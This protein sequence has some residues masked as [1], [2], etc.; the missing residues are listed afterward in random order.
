MEQ[1]EPAVWLWLLVWS[2]LAISPALMLT[3]TLAFTAVWLAFALENAPW[4]VAELWSDPWAW[5]APPH[6]IE[7]SE[8]AVWDWLLDWSVL[9]LL[10]APLRARFA[11]P[12]LALLP[13][14][15]SAPEDG[16]S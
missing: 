11:A 6:P 1:S 2:V 14:E 8:P 4:S 13:P 16:L 9:A 15:G 12:W 3:G 5:P 10:P 7:Q